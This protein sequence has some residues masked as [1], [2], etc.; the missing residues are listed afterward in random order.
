MNPVFFPLLV[1]RHIKLIRWKPN[2]YKL[3]GESGQ[4]ERAEA[5]IARRGDRESAQVSHTAEKMK[6][7]Q[8]TSH[9]LKTRKFTFHSNEPLF[10]MVG[11][12]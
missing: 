2:P 3:G 5:A 7:L 11:Q 8:Q 1:D 4:A 12:I 6:M 10:C 9:L